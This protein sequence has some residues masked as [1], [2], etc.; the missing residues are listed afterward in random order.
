MEVCNLF[1][2]F[3]GGVCCFFYIL[4]LYSSSLRL[5]NRSKS[6]HFFFEVPLL[7]LVYDFEE[8]VYVL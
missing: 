7:M 3:L 8:V 1:I 4:L 5:T 6:F 2:L